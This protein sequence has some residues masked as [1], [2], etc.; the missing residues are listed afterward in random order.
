MPK[1]KHLYTGRAG[2]LAVMAELLFRGWNTAIPEVD[3][4]D[5]IFVVRDSDGNLHRVQVKTS[6][7]KPLKEGHSALFNLSLSQLQAPITPDITYVFA[8]RLD[9]RWDTFVVIDRQTLDEEHRL[10]GIG[11]KNTN[12]LVLRLRFAGK[13]I[14]CSRRDLSQYRND[15]DTR[16]PVIEHL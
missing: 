4:G 5:D 9:D 10:Y 13:S 6:V 3:I 12:S 7:A 11:S 8:V 16:F 1:I 15:W 2:H 14:I